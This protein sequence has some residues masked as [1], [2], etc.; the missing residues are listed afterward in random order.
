MRVTTQGAVLERYARRILAMSDEAVTRLHAADETPTGDLEIAAS[1]MVAEHFLPANLGDYR[2]L[3]P[4]VKLTISVFDSH[5]A[6]GR[7]RAQDCA[8]ALIGAPA[9]DRRFDS[10]P[11]AHD[12]IVLVGPVRGLRKLNSISEL[13]DQPLILREPGSGT[14]RAVAD[15]L[16]AAN[17]ERPDILQVGSTQAARRSVLCGLGYSFISS[18][19]VSEDVRA[20]CLR[21]VKLDGTPVRRWFHAV[22]LRNQTPSPAAKAFFDLLVGDKSARRTGPRPFR[23][24]G[25]M[26]ALPTSVVPKPSTNRRKDIGQIVAT[27]ACAATKALFE[28]AGLRQGAKRDIL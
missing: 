22:R 26:R 16:V 25:A 1:T 4:R 23:P 28:G 9:R 3:Y 2:R 11:F 14:R 6:L 19:A 8:L 7:L 5:E 24:T 27:R 13:S 10:V 12:D 20:K 17:L 21:I 15:L 18:H